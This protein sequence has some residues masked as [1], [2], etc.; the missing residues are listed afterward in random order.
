M[1]KLVKK[2]GRSGSR[3]C[4][5]RTKTTVGLGVTLVYLAGLGFYTVWARTDVL[6]MSPV[7]V[8]EFFAGAFSP[9][10]FFWLVLGFFQQGEELRYSSDALWLQGKELRH[11]V[12]QQRRLV[13]AQEA[14][15]IFDRDRLES[16][17]A[18]ITR[19]AKP[20]FVFTSSG[21]AVEGET[22]PRHLGL[23]NR[24][25]TCTDFRLKLGNETV[26]RSLFETGEDHEIKFDSSTDLM[27]CTQDY[28]A[29][30]IDSL[31][32]RGEQI[33]RIKFATIGDLPF[34]HEGKGIL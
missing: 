6:S 32:E 15:L 34:H 13:T 28:I 3:K 12:E 19:Q 30:F 5:P 4:P 26:C 33:L 9:L 11:S 10:A 23:L 29:T 8:A 1:P 25:A 27:S 14:Q 20:A 31:G 21:F 22:G 17:R 16:H 7:D 24:G 18:E 2:T